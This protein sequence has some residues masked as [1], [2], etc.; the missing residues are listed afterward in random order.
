M[1][2]EEQQ[3]DDVGSGVTNITTQ[4]WNNDFQKALQ[5]FTT[6]QGKEIYGFVAPNGD[7][8]LDETVVSPEH[9]I[10]EYTHLWDVFSLFNPL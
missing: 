3:V 6:L 10:H 9:P 5:L 1:G 7:M 4:Q 8:Y 2:Q